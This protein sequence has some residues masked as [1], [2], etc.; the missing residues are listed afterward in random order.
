MPKCAIEGCPRDERLRRGFCGAHYYRWRVHG[1]PLGGGIDKGARLVFLAE[2]LAS[3]TDDCIIWPFSKTNGYGALHINGTSTQVHR[4]VC[5]KVHGPKP[6]PG[7]HAAHRCG[8]AACCN[9][10][11][12]RW[13]TAAEN[14]AD[15][16]THGTKGRGERMSNAKLT[17]D[18]VR[19]LRRRHSTGEKSN[20]LGPEF[21]ISGRRVRRI[22]SGQAWR[23][24]TDPR[25]PKEE[26]DE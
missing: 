18:M 6:S 16:L 9:P 7:M 8:V 3:D 20:K 19:E 26:D 15:Q 1:D 4:Y 22:V 5:E 11:H 12:V 14:I 21:G 10:R 13:A 24:V 17:D 25:L 2:V 23:H